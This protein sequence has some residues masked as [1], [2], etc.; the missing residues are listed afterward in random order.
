MF[1]DSRDALKKYITYSVCFHV[2]VFILLLL[3]G[4]PLPVAP[5]PATEVVMVRLSRSLGSPES[6]LLKKTGEAAATPPAP[7]APPAPPALPPQEKPKVTTEKTPQTPK[8][9]TAPPK[10]EAPSAKK[11]PAAKSPD[12]AKIAEALA[13]VRGELQQREAQSQAPTGTP[14]TPGQGS[15]FGSPGGTLSAADPEFANYQSQVRSKIIR[16]WV[17]TH[18]GGAEGDPLRTRVVVR[19]NASGNVIST[20]FAKR[21]GDASFD[22]SAL[23]AVE[24]ASPLPPPPAIVMAEAL[25]EG[26]V[27]DFSSR[28]LGR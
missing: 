28:M 27:V 18:T 11:T 17:R 3:F 2:F 12:E 8:A 14:G 22:Q 1:L 24:R 26:F 23:R 5:Q 21:S 16:E 6:P 9:P 25:N 13:G 20:S 4:R 10:T 15:P 7:A 19:I